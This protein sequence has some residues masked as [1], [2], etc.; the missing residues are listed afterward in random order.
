[1]TRLSKPSITLTGTTIM[2]SNSAWAGCAIIAVALMTRADAQSPNL[3]AEVPAE[4]RQV[5]TR[6][7]ET[8]RELATPTENTQRM[9]LD[10]AEQASQAALGSPVHD[11]MIRLSDL[12][13]WDGG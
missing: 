4:A 6:S 1:M 13:A 2:T 9:G 8:F 5:A 3:Q 7:L 10:S 12:K 11:Y